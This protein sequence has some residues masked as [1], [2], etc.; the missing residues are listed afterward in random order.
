[1]L[2]ST[3]SKEL[4]CA[5]IRDWFDHWDGW[6]IYIYSTKKEASEHVRL[7]NEARQHTENGWAYLR[8]LNSIMKLKTQEWDGANVN[9]I[10]KISND[11]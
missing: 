7:Y 4:W 2:E 3:R 10:F 5:C 1:M 11:L 6:E 9:I 8:T